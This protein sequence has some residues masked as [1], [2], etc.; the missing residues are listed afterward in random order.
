[1]VSFDLT[2]GEPVST[3]LAA[4]DTLNGFQFHPYL[5]LAATASG[6]RSCTH[7]LSL[8]NCVSQNASWFLGLLSQRE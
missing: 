6:A 8:P 7:C 3:F 2:T 1:V 5:P 4:T